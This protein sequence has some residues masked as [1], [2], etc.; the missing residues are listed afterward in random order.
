MSTSPPKDKKKEEVK[1]KGLAGITAGDSAVSSVGAG[2]GLNYRGY[3]IEEL[4]KHSTFEEV[5]Y[6]LIFER[7][8][9]LS[10]L[11]EFTRKI[12]AS[13]TIP[14]AL[15]VVLEKI[16]MKAHPMDVMRCI[17]SF[18]GTIEE[19]DIKNNG[20]IP[21]SIRL[22]AIFGPALLYWHHF[23]HSGIRIDGYTGPT[24]TVAMNFMKLF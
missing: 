12:A 21:I 24:D 10:E 4:A 8:P 15:E 13:R 16:P 6:L 23:H 5:F 3:N 14:K 20:P 17:S 1:G 18:L 22:V 2:I 7:L 11:D 19:E 9:T